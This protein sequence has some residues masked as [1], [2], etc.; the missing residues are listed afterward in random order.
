MEESLDQGKFLY[1][2]FCVF[3]VNDQ[4]VYIHTQFKQRQSWLL[5]GWNPQARHLFMR[6][7]WNAQRI[8]FGRQ[9]NSTP[10][11]WRINSQGRDDDETT[12]PPECSQTPS[13]PRE[14]RFQVSCKLWLNEI[15]FVNKPLE[16]ITDF[17]Y[18]SCARPLSTIISGNHTWQTTCHPIAKLYIKWL[19]ASSKFTPKDSSTGTSSRKTCSFQRLASWK[20]PILVSANPPGRP[21]ASRWRAAVPGAPGYTARRNSCSWKAKAKRRET[22]FDATSSLT[23]FHWAAC[24][25]VTSKNEIKA[26]RARLTL[27][28]FSLGCL[29]FSYIKKDIRCHLFQNPKTND[30]FSIISSIVKDK[31]FLEGGE[32][33]CNCSKSINWL[34]FSWYLFFFQ[35][36]LQITTHTNLLTGWPTT[37]PKCVWAWIKW[38]V[39][40]SNCY[41]HKNKNKII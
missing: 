26:I 16:W 19:A 36:L 28:L 3:W 11:S 13:R 7:L 4:I 14:R 21:E 17:S 38:S 9:K 22:H 20:S 25:S 8:T 10:R 30:F 2:T 18:W 27:N 41:P 32:W 29:F 24:S 34:T 37:I 15:Y 31:K 6:L 35:K 40:C 23:S 33:I 5:R 12:R 39:H 1:T